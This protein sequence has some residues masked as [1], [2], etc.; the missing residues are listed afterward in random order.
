MLEHGDIVLSK[1]GVPRV[2]LEGPLDSTPER[3][4]LFY[5]RYVLGDLCPYKNKIGTA[6]I[7][8]I[9]IQ[10]SGYHKPT[11]VYSLTDVVM[12][13]CARVANQEFSA[14]AKERILKTAIEYLEGW[15]DMRAEF[16]AEL[17][18]KE[19]MKKVRA[20]RWKEGPVNSPDYCKSAIKMLSTALAAAGA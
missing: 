13:K 10:K 18:E 16:C 15:L 17:K 9:K 7:H 8:L 19:R 11:T 14:A 4:N 3:W 12:C 1:G 6:W 5:R 20:E 2:V